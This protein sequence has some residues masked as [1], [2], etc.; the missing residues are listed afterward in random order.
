MIDE[1]KFKTKA[2]RHQVVD[3]QSLFNH[4]SFG[5][6]SEMGTGKTK[7]VIDA[8]CALYEEGK[9]DSVLV[10]SPASVRGVWH[11]IDI[12][13]IAKHSWFLN[14]VLEFHAKTRLVWQSSHFPNDVVDKPKK[15]PWVIT[16]YEILRQKKHREALKTLMHGHRFILVLDESSFIKNYRAEQTKAC[17]EIGQ[18]A[19]RRVILNGTPIGNS[20]MDLWSQMLF[21]DRRILPYR[22]YGHFR[23]DYC[24][25]GGWRGKQILSYKNLDKLQRLI[26]PHVIRREKKDCLD[27]PEK[28]YT[29]REAALTEE[30]WKIYKEMRDKAV[31][32]MNENPS[33]AAQAGIVVMRLSQI[34]SGFLGGFVEGDVE[35]V[36]GHELAGA[37]KEISREKLDLLREWVIDQLAENPSRKIIVWCRF[38][39][40]LERVAANLLDILPTYRLYGQAKKE[41][42]QAISMF[43]RIQSSSQEPA[44]LA[45]Q[46]Q[47]GGFGLNLIA[48]DAVA[49]LSQNY[50]L[51]NRLQS[52]D[53]CH[54]PGQTKKVVYL[55]I[56]ATGPKGQ[57]TVDHAVLKAIRSKSEL[58]NWTV[59]AWKQVLEE[60]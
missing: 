15:L 27:L 5:L 24:N 32:W 2:Y 31:V 9:I 43:S 41:R 56:I 55:D 60:E 50:S 53:R 39:P 6:L 36:D 46:E 1:S 13:E 18:L 19:A 33:M 42:E 12:G 40:E 11:D 8:A 25:M 22:W 37:T 20:P 17:I 47:A 3:A 21:L 26:G 30:T 4:T 45:A 51:M 49:Y 10:V 38:R 14:S 35:T 54:R 59:A 57:K 28:I 7:T 23:N 48:A 58:A 16:N 34:T 44:L 52:E 29:Q